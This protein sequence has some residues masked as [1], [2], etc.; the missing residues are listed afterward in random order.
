M[1]RE[2]FLGILE[3]HPGFLPMHPDFSK[4]EKCQA[5]GTRIMIPAEIL[6]INIDFK[7]QS[8]NDDQIQ[9]VNKQRGLFLAEITCTSIPTRF[10]LQIDRQ[11]DVFLA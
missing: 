11:T 1:H 6:S 5:P 3:E 10:R 7:M 2:V 4:E 8:I 9:I